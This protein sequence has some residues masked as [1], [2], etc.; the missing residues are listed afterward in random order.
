MT[1]LERIEAAQNLKRF[2]RITVAPT[3]FGQ[4][5]VIRE[6]GREGRKPCSSAKSGSPGLVQL[7]G[8]I[9]VEIGIRLAE[10][11]KSHPIAVPL[12]NG[13]FLQGAKTSRIVSRKPVCRIDFV[14][15]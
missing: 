7:V 15:V 1:Y 13:L 14:P 10:R 6:W 5:A 12:G 4:W 3:L 2:Y 11:E 8:V 9:I